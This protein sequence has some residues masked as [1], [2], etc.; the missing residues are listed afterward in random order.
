[1]NIIIIM[2]I[3]C[4]VLERCFEIIIDEVLYRLHSRNNAKIVTIIKNGLT[5]AQYLIKII[6]YLLIVPMAWL[7]LT[8]FVHWDAFVEYLR[9]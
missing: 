5:Y 2:W 4:L 7:F 8:N 1:M 6:R 9:S 3:S